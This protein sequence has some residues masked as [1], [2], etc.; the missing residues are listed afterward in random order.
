M[1]ALISYG[2]LM[3]KLFSINMINLNIKVTSVAR[4]I[5]LDSN[6]GVIC[7]NRGWNKQLTIPLTKQFSISEA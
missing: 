7:V 6:S 3:Q 5:A 2:L 4:Y 1:V